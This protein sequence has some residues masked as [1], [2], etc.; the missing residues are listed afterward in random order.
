[1]GFHH[2]YVFTEK[3]FVYSSI[4]GMVIIEIVNEIIVCVVDTTD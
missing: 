1:M 4:K 2:L 3:V